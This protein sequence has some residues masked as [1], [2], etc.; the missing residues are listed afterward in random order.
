M[1]FEVDQYEV[2]NRVKQNIVDIWTGKSTA[3]TMDK[4]LEDCKRVLNNLP[5]YKSDDV[6]EV[7][8]NIE[9]CLGIIK[10]MGQV[11]DESPIKL[12]V[13]GSDGKKRENCS[14]CGKKFKDEE[15]GIDTC[16]HTEYVRLCWPCYRKAGNSVR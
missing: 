13:A 3:I 2:N 9:V 6:H 11:E 14:F 8:I 1:S 12:E 10:S 5:Q 4:V 16:T 7:L 15:D